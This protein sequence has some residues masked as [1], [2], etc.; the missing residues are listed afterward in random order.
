MGSGTRRNGNQNVIVFSMDVRETS[1]PGSCSSKMYRSWNQKERQSIRLCLMHVP[2]TSFQ[3][4]CSSKMYSSC[5]QV[6]GIFRNY[7]HVVIALF[8]AFSLEDNID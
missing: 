8:A 1:F 7:S 5:D 6:T 3:G 2:E 4:S